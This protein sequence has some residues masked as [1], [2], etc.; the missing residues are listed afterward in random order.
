MLSASSNLHESRKLLF[1][2][3]TNRKLAFEKEFFALIKA[4]GIQNSFIPNQKIK[5][6]KLLINLKNMNKKIQILNKEDD[7]CIPNEP[8]PIQFV[9]NPLDFP[10][11]T[12]LKPS[13]PS[14]SQTTV[15]IF[16]QKL[17]NLLKI[18]YRNCK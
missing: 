3:R 1:S 10:W 14:P 13:L 16:T 9:Y 11:E 4:G 8:Y 7:T 17:L 18:K 15:G 5:L 12:T 2:V 6:L